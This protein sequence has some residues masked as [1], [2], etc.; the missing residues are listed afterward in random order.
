MPTKKTK[1]KKNT[2]SKLAKNILKEQNKFYKNLTKILAKHSKEEN[3]AI[4][5]MF[6]NGTTVQTMKKN[7][8][9]AKSKK[10]KSNSLVKLTQSSIKIQ[11]EFEK[12]ILIVSNK[13]SSSKVTDTKELLNNINKK[14]KSNNKKM[15]KDIKKLTRY[16]FTMRKPLKLKSGGIKDT[17]KEKY[18]KL[19]SKI[20]KETVKDKYDE[21]KSKPTGIQDPR[22]IEK[23]KKI[24]KILK[25]TGGITLIGLAAAGAAT[26][27]MDLTE[28]QRTAGPSAGLFGEDSWTDDLDH[29]GT[30]NWRDDDI[31]GDGIKNKDDA[32]D[33]GWGWGV[34]DAKH[35]PK[36]YVEEAHGHGGDQMSDPQINQQIDAHCCDPTGGLSGTKGYET[37]KNCSEALLPDGITHPTTGDP[38]CH[39]KGHLL[40]PTDD[41]EAIM[42]ADDLSWGDPPVRHG[43]GDIIPDNDS[44]GEPIDTNNFDGHASDQELHDL[45]YPP[46]V[47]YQYNPVN[48][49]GNAN[50]LLKEDPPEH[51]SFDECCDIASEQITNTTPLDDEDG[52][53]DN[54]SDPQGPKLCEQTAVGM[55]GQGD[56]WC[57]QTYTLLHTGEHK[58]PPLSHLPGNELIYFN[59][60]A[61]LTEGTLD[62]GESG[63][64]WDERYDFINDNSLIF[65]R[66]CFA[67][68]DDDHRYHDR[69]LPINWGGRGAEAIQDN[70]EIL[71]DVNENQDTSEDGGSFEF[72]GNKRV[73]ESIAGEDLQTRIQNYNHAADNPD[74]KV[75]GDILHGRGLEPD[76][77]RKFANVADATDN[78]GNGPGGFIYNPG[79]HAAYGDGDDSFGDWFQNRHDSMVSEYSYYGTQDPHTY[80]STNP[81]GDTYLSDPSMFRPDTRRGFMDK[82]LGLN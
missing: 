34:D 43:I 59:P 5:N 36:D 63:G 32:N 37:I 61:L 12:Y 15:N 31:D 26:G 25:T 4:L 20:N 2:V 75:S 56:D 23:K 78:D 46:C 47:E 55:Y 38:H 28:W 16:F 68:T 40:G 42:N 17:V 13:I 44:E 50:C 53:T 66:C 65:E 29:D 64:E 79:T 60:A 22:E 74:E 69:D 14:N 8:K 76:S 58:W 82:I 33:D 67:D 10:T 19:K 18:G 6:S 1:N 73:D 51:G 72:A 77:K 11:K 49:L 48:Q 9:G 3:K 39:E 24:K 21:L 70:P 62:K 57:A 35:A 80:Q 7:K 71:L 45:K 30:A 54:T 27:I 41:H 52:V 81:T